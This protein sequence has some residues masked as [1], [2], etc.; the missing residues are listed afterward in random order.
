MGGKQ[1]GMF[2][3]P[4]V[5]A[6]VDHTMQVM[7]DETFGPILPIMKVHD[8]THAIQMANHSDMGLSAYV[9]SRNLA[10]AKRVAE[11]IQAGIVNINDAMSHYPVSLLPFG[12]VKMSGN[13]RTHGEGEVTQFTHTKS[14]AVGAPPHPLD[15]ATMVRYPGAYRLG[16]A[17]LGAF[18]GVTPQQRVEPLADFLAHDPKGQMVTKAAVGAGAVSLAG[19]AVAG[20]LRLRK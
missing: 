14:Y 3:E 17:I 1:Q 18:F 4:T 9:W 19:L 2:I 20:L 13:A 11:Q 10:H 12:G 15:P 8:D 7:T 6:D 5:L 16:K